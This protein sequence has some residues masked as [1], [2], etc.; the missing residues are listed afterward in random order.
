MLRVTK[1]MTGSGKLQ[2]IFL[3][4]LQG[5]FPRDFS[6]VFLRDLQGVFPRDFS[7]VFLRDLQGVLNR[8]NRRGYPAFSRRL[9]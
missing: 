2:G 1:T 3:R 5:V 8:Q 4:D 7:G 9:R 6:G